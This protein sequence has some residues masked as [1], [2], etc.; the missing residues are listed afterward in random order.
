M[1]LTPTLA[2]RVAAMLTHETQAGHGVVIKSCRLPGKD[3]AQIWALTEALAQRR[4]LVVL[5][6]S[7]QAHGQRREGK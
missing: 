1:A 2:E 3:R 7:H 4:K 5:A 6:G